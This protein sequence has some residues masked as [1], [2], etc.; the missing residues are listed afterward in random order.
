MSRTEKY[1]VAILLAAFCQLPARADTKATIAEAVK[2]Y[3][4]GQY[5]PAAVLLAKELKENPDDGKLHYYLGLALKKQGYDVKALRE[6]EMAVRLCP[7]DMI[8]SFAQ[9]KLDNLSQPRPAASP[10]KAE[11][12]DWL[13]NI[14]SGISDSINQVF[15]GKKNAGA[16]GAAAV[17][18]A[19]A[20]GP[21]DF[22]GSAKQALKQGKDLVKKVGGAA[23]YNNRRQEGPAEVMSMSEM[24][25]LA[26]RSR[27]MNL[28]DWASHGDG[29]K[30]F[31]QAPEG[32][33]AW[34][35]WIS[36]FKKSFQHL[37]MRHIDSEALEQTRGAAACI[38]SVDRQGNLRGQ[39]YASTADAKLNKCLV[40]TI[41]ELNHSRILAFPSNSG[42]SGWNF[43]MTWNFG[44][45]LTYLHFFH[46]RQKLIDEARVQAELALT[47]AR[48]QAEKEKEKAKRAKALRLAEE[49]RREFEKKLQAQMANQ[50]KTE[51]MGHV[52]G[53]P[54][55]REL[56][57]VALELKDLT[58]VKMPAGG[59]EADPFAGITDDTIQSWPD[60][61]R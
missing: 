1:L 40:E 33:A 52:V 31:A 35:Y 44:T 51:V 45:L 48:I 53:Q 57:A 22:F 25:N 28:P 36:R 17:P 21:F 34:D 47:Q 13:A 7:D 6:L 15:G 50:V 27:T 24:L 26:E 10:P 55:I 5:G 20:A 46:A 11:S 3:K 54:T 49:K 60:L 42:I 18:D 4:A 2:A 59:V 30:V 38:F 37:L 12:K 8:A 9:E 14:T 43:Q 29:V 23:N 16:S 39:I 41:R 56:K 32:S 61:N 58:P 19:P